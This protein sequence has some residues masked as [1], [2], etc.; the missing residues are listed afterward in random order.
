[1][2]KLFKIG[3]AFGFGYWIGSESSYTAAA[4]VE[5]GVLF[6][7]LYIVGSWLWKLIKKRDARLSMEYKEKMQNKANNPGF[8]AK[9]GQALASASA[10]AEASGVRRCPHCR[11]GSVTYTRKNALGHEVYDSKTCIHCHGSGRV[12]VV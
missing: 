7:I 1:M 10:S 9:I 4:G 6:A 5:K 12:S 8:F 11:D 2:R 3:I